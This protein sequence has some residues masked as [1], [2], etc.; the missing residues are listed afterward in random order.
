MKIDVRINS[1]RPEG[2][3]RA[4]ASVTLDEMFAIRGVKIMEGKNGLFV[5]LPGYKGGDGQW[6]DTIIP[7]T[8]EARAQINEVAIAAYHQTLTQTQNQGQQPAP[9]PEEAPE[10]VADMAMSM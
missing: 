9:L 5:N 1:I 10:P 8:K 6:K 4:T 3:T 2:T 7:I